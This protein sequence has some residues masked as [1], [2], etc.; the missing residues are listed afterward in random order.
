MRLHG[1]NAV[2]FHEHSEQ[3]IYAPFIIII[4]I[5]IVL[6]L[7]LVYQISLKQNGIDQYDKD[8]YNIITK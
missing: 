5:A 7:I 2:F 3:L 1:S 4:F 8:F 6:S